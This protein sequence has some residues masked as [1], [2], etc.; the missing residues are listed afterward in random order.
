MRTSATTR[1][2]LAYDFF[3]FV[4]GSPAEVTAR[5]TSW[6]T[7]FYKDLLH[8]ENCEFRSKPPRFWLITFVRSNGEKVYAAVLPDGTIVEPRTLRR[9]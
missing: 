2:G 4:S 3:R 7:H 5:A 8:I 1:G 6:A 9:S